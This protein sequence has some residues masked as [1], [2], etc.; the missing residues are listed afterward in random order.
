MRD[1]KYSEELQLISELH[2]R[3]KRKWTFLEEIGV[4]SKETII[5][6]LLGYYF[7]PNNKHGLGD[8]F[9]KSL[10][11][12]ER[13]K[14]NEHI[15][16]NVQRLKNQDKYEWA[17]V[18]I[19]DTTDN[20][21]RID[22]VIETK[23]QIIAIEFKIN[24]LLNNPL[25]DY[26]KYINEEYGNK[27]KVFIVLTPIWKK[28]KE[29]AICG[30]NF[31]QIIL[32]KFIENVEKNKEL[33]GI[34]LNEE[35]KIFYKDFINTVENRKIIYE[36]VKQYKN[37]VKEDSANLQ[38]LENIFSNLNLIKEKLNKENKKLLNE[39]IIY[40]FEILEQSVDKIE[41]VIKT[42]F[43]KNKELKVRNSLKG[44]TVEQW[45][46]KTEKWQIDKIIYENTE[47]SSSELKQIV[48]DFF[49]KQ[50]SN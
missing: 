19:E 49:N 37:F 34:V 44:V 10:L 11:E 16:S 4:S 36:M 47:F 13:Y 1:K 48:D 24:H 17:N 25:A 31:E 42:R 23:N 38:R 14:L 28:A 12:T 6:K 5:A 41:S 26:E 46:K 18:I 35:Q 27:E 40:K 29:K 7:N 33:K 9:I 20:N 8:V 22:I 30:I 39:F 32:S 45:I 15:K 2:L 21:N 43:D 3:K 50:I